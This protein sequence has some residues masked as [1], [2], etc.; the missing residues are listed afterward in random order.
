[1]LGAA[2]GFFAFG[3]SVDNRG[4]HSLLLEFGSDDLGHGA[5]VQALDRTTVGPAYVWLAGM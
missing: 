1:M 5:L 4:L 3:V 2:E